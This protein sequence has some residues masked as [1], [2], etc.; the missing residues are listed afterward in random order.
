MAIFIN[1]LMVSSI[2]GLSAVT[3]SA[4][5]SILVRSTPRLHGNHRVESRCTALLSEQIVVD[6]FRGICTL[7]EE[8]YAVFNYFN[9]HTGRNTYTI[10]DLFGKYTYYSVDP[11]LN[12]QVNLSDFG[13]MTAFDVI[14]M[15]L[16]NRIEHNITEQDK[17]KT[18]AS[19]F[20]YTYPTREGVHRQMA[21]STF[22][23]DYITTVIQKADDTKQS[24]IRNDMKNFL[25]DCPL[26]KR[27]RQVIDLR[28][29]GATF[30]EMAEALSIK[31]ATVEGHL[32][33]AEHNI[34][35]NWNKAHPNDIVPVSDVSS[36]EGKHK[37][38]KR[39]NKLGI[40]YGKWD[41]EQSHF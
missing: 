17:S 41:F 18:V 32:Y 13:V 26:A 4:L 30:E 28:K 22:T 12:K 6:D 36:Y 31:K 38:K 23:P 9:H 8:G 27:Q 25:D 33:I 1:G 37:S 34:Q 20:D 14:M 21:E 5:L 15:D 10:S 7:Y 19:D 35:K 24:Q 29:E 11:A 40:V 16:S 3:F 39:I 2:S